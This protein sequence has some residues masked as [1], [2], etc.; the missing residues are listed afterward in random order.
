MTEHEKIIQDTGAVSHECS[1]QA[2]VGL[3]KTC[4]CLGTPSDIL[5]I[6]NNGF[7]GEL[8]AIQNG[9]GIVFGGKDLI[10][11][12]MP[13]QLDN[14]HCTFLSDDGKC[15]LH[16][17]GIKPLEGKLATSHI[18]EVMGRLHMKP[19]PLAVAQTW[20][21]ERNLKTVRLIARALAKYRMREIINERNKS[22]K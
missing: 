7:I 9:V 12:I 17:L 14:G 15:K 3:C 16:P 10:P 2:C 6:I 1:C 22:K 5:R 13:V 4:P 20:E 8:D 21:D 19:L 18:S 11:L